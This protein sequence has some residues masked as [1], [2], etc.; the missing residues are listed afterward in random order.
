MTFLIGTVAFLTDDVTFL[1]RDAAFLIDDATFL[2]DDATFLIGGVA[3]LIGDAASSMRSATELIDD[4]TESIRSVASSI[5]S[6]ASPMKS[7]AEPVHPAT[8]PV[9]AGVDRPVAVSERIRCNRD[10]SPSTPPE[11]DCN[12]ESLMPQ[13]TLSI[14]L[15]N[16]PSPLRNAERGT[17]NAERKGAPGALCT[18]GNESGGTL[19]IAR[20]ENERA[21]KKQGKRSG[22]K[23]EVGKA[24][25]GAHNAPQAF[26]LT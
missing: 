11:T 18:P 16:V 10:R 13:P 23:S 7:V 14:F 24:R 21:G 4:A 26:A 20:D 5:G 12:A 8:E 25:H 2:T 9:K 22:G 6:V 15:E 1:I 19:L 17:R 3:F